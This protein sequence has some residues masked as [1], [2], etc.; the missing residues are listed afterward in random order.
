MSSELERQLERALGEA[1]GPD[2]GVTDRALQSALEALPS[3]ADT[4]R[5]RRRR[6]VLL[7][8]ACI[9]AFVSGGVTLAATDGRLPGIGPAL[10]SGRPAASGA[11]ALHNAPLVAPAEVISALIGDHG[12]VVTAHLARTFTDHHLT[13]FAAS[14]AALYAI[15]ARPGHLRAVQAATGRVAW[16]FGVAGT[17]AN[18]VWAPFPIRVVYLLN[19]RG[20]L[21]VHDI[22]GNGTHDF[23]VHASAAPV[24]PSWRWDSKAFAFVRSDGA[25]VVHDVIGGR[26]VAI[27]PA[28][29]LHTA[30][31]V[32]F[33]P[34]G[35]RLAIA[36][37]DGHLRV[38][39][40]T[41]RA[42]ALCTTIA[43]GLPSIGWLGGRQLLV[44][45]GSTLSRI[46]I[47]RV[48]TGYDA[49]TT[50]GTIAG[51][52]ASPDGR[53]VVLAL[54]SGGRQRVVI[55][56]TPRFSEEAGP[57]RILRTLADGPVARRGPVPLSWL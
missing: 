13:G 54:D 26:D 42:P 9:A 33:A 47:H 27:R 39:D 44:G 49:T 56:T 16:R 21:E 18:P 55:A 3:P 19:G 8:A 2:P 37:R 53:R 36:D 35:G 11:P 17:P 23:T 31:A 48:G 43:R 4:R 25:V 24:A 57:L 1:P 5:I 6:I 34:S 12:L 20:G 30:A 38:V 45:A 29:G 10:T 32:A 41:G 50:P 15:E 52:A 46:V 28:C 40:T 22:W 51:L 14:P 7:L